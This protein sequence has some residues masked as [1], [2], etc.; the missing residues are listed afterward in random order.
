MSLPDR[1]LAGQLVNCTLDDGRYR[2]VKSLGVGTYGE[3]YLIHDRLAP[4]SS[5]FKAMKCIPTRDFTFTDAVSRLNEEIRLHLKVPP[6]PNVV[7]LHRVLHVNDV[8][9]MILDYVPGGDMYEN[10]VNHPAFKNPVWPDHNEVVRDVFLQIA[11]AVEHCHRYGV[12]HRDLKPENVILLD[13]RIVDFG[14][15]T[16]RI[17]SNEIGCGSAYYMSCETQGGL[18]R[19]LV[20]YLTAPNDVWALGVILVNLASGRNPWNQAV[21]DDPIFYRYYMDRTFLKQAL[22]LTDEFA[23]ILRYVFTINPENRIK[24][25]DLYKMVAS[26]SRF[27]KMAD[28]YP[29]P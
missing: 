27:M 20:G 28:T 29:A 10:I 3:V 25:H 5:E 12:Y 16:D 26:C 4:V 1:K 14:L 11:Q 2:L 23:Q 21:I 13:V 15:A 7:R 17:W 9:F 22:P 24:L 18:N 6:H 8:V 19:N